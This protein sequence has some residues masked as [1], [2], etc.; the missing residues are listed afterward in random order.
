MLHHFFISI[1]KDPIMIAMLLKFN[2]SDWNSFIVG[3][4]LHI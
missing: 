4:V 1:A 2:S 3:Y